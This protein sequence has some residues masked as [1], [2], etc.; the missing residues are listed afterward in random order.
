MI[1]T[2]NEEIQRWNSKEIEWYHK[3]PYTQQPKS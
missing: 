1:Q 3:S 2:H